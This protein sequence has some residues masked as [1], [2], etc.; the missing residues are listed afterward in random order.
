MKTVN[1]WQ[2]NLFTSF[3]GTTYFKESVDFCRILLTAFMEIDC[4]SPMGKWFLQGL[5][6]SD[7]NIFK[8]ILKTSCGKKSNYATLQCYCQTV[9]VWVQVYKPLTH[10]ISLHENLQASRLDTQLLFNSFVISH[11]SQTNKTGICSFLFSFEMLII[12]KLSLNLHWDQKC[13]WV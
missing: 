5:F 8:S 2:L 6:M 3:R 12:S 13:D 9:S 4:W 7:R 1:A 10:A 11:R